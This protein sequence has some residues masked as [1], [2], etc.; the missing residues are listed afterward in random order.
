MS[1]GYGKRE[2]LILE[3]IEQKGGWLYLRDIL[4][5]Q[6]TKAEYNA[7]NRAAGK[8]IDTGKIGGMHYIIELKKVTVGPV[9]TECD[10][11][12][13]DLE[14]M[15]RG[16]PKGYA[17]QCSQG[18]GLPDDNLSVGQCDNCPTPQHL[19]DKSWEGAKCCIRPTLMCW[20]DK[21]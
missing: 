4:P 2:R 9:G 15:K 12:K 7:L 17:Y 11:H 19:E 18:K 16:R 6:Y 3:A 13:L 8:L 20:R 5:A 14:D 1:R 21:R 10:R